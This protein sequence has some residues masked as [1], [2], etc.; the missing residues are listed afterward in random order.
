MWVGGQRHV[1]AALPPRKIRYLLYRRLGGPQGRSG[2]VRKISPSPDFDTRTV[3]SVA[4]RYTDW[5]ILEPMMNH[6]VYWLSHLAVKFL[7][8]RRFTCR[9]C[10][11]DAECVTFLTRNA[12]GSGRD[13]RHGQRMCGCPYH[14]PFARKFMSLR[15]V[16]TRKWR[17]ARLIVA[18]KCW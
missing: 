1:P 5:A 18:S 16:T 17:A 8:I 4:S 7:W 12:I 10:S 14:K 3:Q 11:W 15:S 9:T 6:I 13:Y 2:R